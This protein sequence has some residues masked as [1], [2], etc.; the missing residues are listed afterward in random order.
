MSLYATGTP[1]RGLLEL[2][3][4]RLLAAFNAPAA[5]RCTKATKLGLSSAIRSRWDCTS[6]AGDNSCARTRR[7]I[8]Q[9]VRKQGSDSDTA[10]LPSSRWPNYGRLTDLAELD[11][12]VVR[13][14]AV[15]NE[16]R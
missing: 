8:S 10:I 6:S 13:A 4:A 1:A 16:R 14:L 3:H 9:A 12:R 7:A 5:S 2:S 11:V 15:R